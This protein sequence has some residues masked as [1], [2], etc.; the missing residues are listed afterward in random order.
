[1]SSRE[2]GCRVSLYVL[3]GK[4]EEMTMSGAECYILFGIEVKI[5]GMMSDRAALA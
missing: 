4:H 2:V 3:L 5:I 1:M